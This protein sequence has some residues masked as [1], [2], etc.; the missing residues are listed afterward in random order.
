VSIAFGKLYIAD[1]NNHAIRVADLKTKR[2]E[3]LQIKG[4][5]KLRTRARERQFTGEV[6]EAAQQTIEPGDATL[7]LQLEL[8]AGY[9]LNS[10]APTTVQIASAQKQTVS[11]KDSASENIRNPKFPVSIPIKAVEGETTVEARF[12]I[13]YC[14]AAKESLCYIKE[15]KVTLPVKVKKGAGARSLTASYKLNL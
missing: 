2:V 6:I 4:L 3:T 8:P 5:E 13:Y 1:T 14:E 7:K 15:A 11:V 10:L 9:K 12:I